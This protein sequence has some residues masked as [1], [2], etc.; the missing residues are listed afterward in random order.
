MKKVWI[1]TTLFFLFVFFAWYM[2]IKMGKDYIIP[3]QK[4]ETLAAPIS[5]SKTHSQYWSMNGKDIMLLGGSVEDNLFQ[6]ENI[7]RQL[8]LLKA[9]GGN[10][11][12]NTMSS[13]D[14]SDVWA[15]AQNEDGRYDLRKW[16]DE[17]WLRFERFLNACAERDI[18]VQIELWATFDFYRDFWEVNPFNPKNNVNY[19]SER[20]Q[21]PTVVNSH[22]TWTE[23]NF[24][25]SIPS[26][27]NNLL[28]LG[29]QQRYI[30]K[31][32]AIS[33]EYGNVLYCMDNETSVTSE[34]G[35]FWSLYIKK[36]AK[37]NGKQIF[38]TEMWDPWNLDH[39][40]HRETFDH[41]ETYD[42]V[43]I[44]QNNHNS[45]DS[46]WT[47]GLKQI[48][49][50]KSNDMLR[51]LNNVKVYGNDGGRHQTT[52]NAIESYIRNVLFGAA[53][54]R[55]HRPTSG[56][57][58]NETAQG[59]IT[60]MRSYITVADFFNAVPANHLL[61]VREENEAF[62][63]AIEDKEYAIYFPK[64]GNVILNTSIENGDFSIKWLDILN[65]TWTEA[66]SISIQ[67]SKT[68]INAPDHKNWLAF[69][70]TK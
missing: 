67:N 55:F 17:Y 47:N 23:N 10:Y 62:C 4:K 28:L 59:V 24:F 25:W 37:E 9:V 12:R 49:R 7:E 69:I 32:L 63:R 18:V 43:D 68:I 21:V 27:E 39:V 38:T 50:L 11:V 6:I 61:S 44:S 56:Q 54:S 8:D 16:N 13:R 66:T 53:S 58:L 70:K 65:A 5:I 45:G 51:P 57:G 29:F 46:H 33:L 1:T 30:D 42:F 41:P 48:N 26:Q 40:A 15:F 36:V 22:P 20:I 35:K 34:W 3:N 19:T 52:Q 2:V 64:G 31:L 14:S 60:S